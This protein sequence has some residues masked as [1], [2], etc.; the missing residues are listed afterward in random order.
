MLHP[1]ADLLEKPPQWQPQDLKLLVQEWLRR[2]LQT[3]AL[4]C[5]E[6]MDGRAVIRAVSPLLRQEVLLREYELL[7]FVKEQGLKLQQVVARM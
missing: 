7:V 4:Y 5:E 2:E 6:V 3:D 1:L